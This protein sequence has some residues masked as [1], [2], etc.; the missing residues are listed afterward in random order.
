MTRESTREARHVPYIG[1]AEHGQRRGRVGVGAGKVGLGGRV[2]LCLCLLLL[3][4]LLLLLLLLLLW[5]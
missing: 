3:C 4:G 5:W 2:G 1:A